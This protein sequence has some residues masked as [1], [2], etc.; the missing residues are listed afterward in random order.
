MGY[1]SVNHVKVWTQDEL[2]MLEMVGALVTNAVLKKRREHDLYQALHQAEVAN[3]SKS[4]PCRFAALGNAPN[5][6]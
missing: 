3:L 6:T 4:T 2:K 1:D 5:F